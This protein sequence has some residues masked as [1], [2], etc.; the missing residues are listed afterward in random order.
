VQGHKRRKYKAHSLIDKVYNE[1][2]LY[3]AWRRVRRNKG[4]HGLDRVTIRM[5]EADLEKHLG[6]IQRKLIQRRYQPQPVRRVY[7]PKASNPRERRP[8]GIPVVADRVVGQALLQVLDPLFDHELSDASFGYRKGR[9]AQDAVAAI[10]QA[11]RDGFR[12]VLD[13]D[14]KSFFDQLDHGVV[15]SR[16]RA[17]IADGR[18]LDLIEAFLKAGVYEE[19]A[20]SV[21][22][23]GCPQGGVI[24]PWLSNLVLDDLDKALEA[25]GY[26]HVRYAD[27]FVILCRTRQEAEQ[28]RV[29]VAEVLEEL[30]LSL[31]EDKTHVVNSR[32]G[33]EFLGFRFRGGRVGVRHKAIERFKD[34]VRTLTRR[35]QG[36]NVEAVL[37]D[38]NPVLRGYAKYFG[39]AEVTVLFRR[40]DAWVR[41][42]I[43]S[44]KMQRR[45]RR[46]NHRLSKRRLAKWGLLSLQKCRPVL[47]LFTR[48]S[49]LE[50]RLG[51][52]AMRN[53]RGV[54]QCG[55]TTC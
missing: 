48:A 29:F 53:P 26:R 9:G 13:A 19:G 4:A 34:K 46:D 31:N 21:P 30:K 20:V 24:S 5:F 8:L 25:R 11:G 49:I 28:A 10:I 47:T 15:M 37:G 54:A 45:S 50:S 35:Q 41:M 18:V 40:L 16:V 14:I 1:K 12:S 36:R 43:R 33:F 39:S 3:T 42:R 32:D 22:T 51:L 38:L 44:F 2:N 6:E 27:D 23:W 7:I 52:L 17:R 55:N